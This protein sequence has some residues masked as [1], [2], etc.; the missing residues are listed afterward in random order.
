MTINW[1]LFKKFAIF[2]IVIMVISF[3]AA[4]FLKPSVTDFLNLADSDNNL[5]LSSD[6]TT[7]FVQY[8]I[9]NGVKVPFQMFLLTFIP[10]PL[11]YFSPIILTAVLTGI[12]FYVPFMPGLE[13]KLNLI[14][15]M[16]GTFPH[17]FIEIFGFLIVACGLYSV[18]KS[19]R[20]K[21]FRKKTSNLPFFESIKQ[22]LLMYC[23]VALP[24][25]IIAAFIEAFITPMVG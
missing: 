19:I 4:Y 6:R 24:T 7:A 16:L 22:L 9:N 23:L 15:I 12:V 13:G 10:I 3:F 21:L 20:S 8:V 17:M 14:D 25:I 18:N 2:F 5:G 11:V 1:K